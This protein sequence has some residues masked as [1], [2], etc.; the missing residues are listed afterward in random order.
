MAT[1]SSQS[2]IDKI[3][4]EVAQRKTEAKN[5]PAVSTP[6]PTNTDQALYGSSWTNI[7]VKTPTT[8]PT[9]AVPPTTTTPTK[10]TTVPTQT[11]TV[12]PWSDQDVFWSWAWTLKVKWKSA[13]TPAPEMNTQTQGGTNIQTKQQTAV[14]D[15]NVTRS[16]QSSKDLMQARALELQKSGMS[17]EDIY[18][19]M[20]KEEKVGKF[21]WSDVNKKDPNINN[22][23][24]LKEIAQKN[25]GNIT[26]DGMLM[27]IM[28]W[29][30]M[31]R[32]GPNHD[33]AKLRAKEV[34]TLANIP[35]EQIA[36]AISMNQILPGSQKLLDLQQFYPEIYAQVEQ[37]YMENQKLWTINNFGN[38]LFSNL[39][40]SNKDNAWYNVDSMGNGVWEKKDYM[41]ALE[42]SIYEWVARNMWEDSQEYLAF[43]EEQ[44]A[45][46]K[47]QLQKEK[48]IKLN[49]EAMKLNDL[50]S[51]TE[52]QVRWAL[53]SE[54]PEAFISAYV[55]EMTGDLYQK[56]DSVN[57]SLF[58][59]QALLTAY[60]EEIQTKTA[61]YQYA[62]GLDMQAKQAEAEER[63]FQYTQKL[64][65]FKMNMDIQKLAMDAE[66]R[67]YNRE[68]NA[69]LDK[70][71]RT[72]FY[73][74]LWFNKQKFAQDQ[75]NYQQWLQRDYQKFQQQMNQQ[76]LKQYYDLMQDENTPIQMKADI[77]DYLFNG[78]QPWTWEPLNVWNAP[79]VDVSSGYI[80]SIGSGTITSFWW[81]H[82]KF[83]WIDIDWKIGDPIPTLWWTV[84]KIGTRNGVQWVKWWYG[85]Y[86]DV[87]DANGYTHRYA[88]L[89][90][91][92]VKVWDTVWKWW[93]IWTMGNTWYV[94]KGAWWD[95]S[96]LDYSIRKPNGQAF[97]SKEALGYIKTL[98]S[99]KG[100]KWTSSP[101]ITEAKNVNSPVLNKSAPQWLQILNEVK[102]PNSPVVNKWL[103]SWVTPKLPTKS[104][105][106][107]YKVDI[108]TKPVIFPQPDLPYNPFRAQIEQQKE[109]GP[110][111]DNV[112]LPFARKFIETWNYEPKDLLAMGID[113]KEFQARAIDVY[114]K[115]RASVAQKHDFEVI[116]PSL[117]IGK[118]QKEIADIYKSLPVAEEM[119]SKM[120]EYRDL[121]AKV[122]T[123][124]FPTKSKRMLE[125]LHTDITLWLKEKI[126]GYD[127]WVLNGKD[128]EI[129]VK[130]FPEATNKYWLDPTF[131][132]NIMSS[133]DKAI[134]NATNKVQK[135]S[136]SFWLRYNPGYSLK[137][138]QDPFWL[139]IWGNNNNNWSDPLGIF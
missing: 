26:A 53:P 65:E 49:D 129:L 9:K 59:E 52:D 13:T 86:V 50:I 51:K 62:K 71:D 78:V 115:D 44:L 67:I 5:N 93:V 110:I 131:R 48:V 12:T 75:M 58:T 22:K 76:E 68:R 91:I 106:P 47:I 96:H 135:N 30:D 79:T 92:D 90:K 99:G 104:Q 123:E 109:Q 112:L 72:Q 36:G 45:D 8:T 84:T 29:N 128:W 130:S 121:V 100:A 139:G 116:E 77:Y 16:S 39:T 25:I 46:P 85:N 97:S 21:L 2:T 33:I 88:H 105:E 134:M 69:E 136:A 38:S 27:G 61:H 137:T 95:G 17:K 83:Q 138:K 3:K 6:Q 126:Q 31:E 124:S 63:K 117:L 54:A 119:L 98:E 108:P 102:N 66:D 43:V 41:T 28:S 118:T 114:I 122:G 87:K 40:D 56:L 101:Q 73:E 120:K 55:Q 35:V 127:L 18:S 60:S 133:I 57:R 107:S 32:W 125:T 14:P 82:D 7:K 11:K 64:D 80:N 23:E 113:P 1:P 37:Q 111:A 103:L 70:W 81:T 19:T 24:I 15:T 94:I 42:D 89:D 10:T 74:T 20:V 34:K 132:V 4:A